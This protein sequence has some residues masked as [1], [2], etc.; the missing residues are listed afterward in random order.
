MN[1]HKGGKT[2]HRKISGGHRRV[3]E[4]LTEFAAL[5]DEARPAGALTT[6]VVA[7]GAVLAATHLGT[8]GTVEPGRTT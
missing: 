5:P 2:Q 1:E 8:V 4:T 6:D 7:V 3:E